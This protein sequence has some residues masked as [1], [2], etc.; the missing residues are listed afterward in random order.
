VRYLEFEGTRDV[1]SWLATPVAIDFQA[2]LGWQPIRERMAELAAYTRERIRLPLATP[3]DRRMSGAMTAFRLPDG[4]NVLALRKALW[5]H[6]IEIPVIERPDRLL[7]RVSHHFYTTEA[8]IDR[9]ADVLP[10][11]LK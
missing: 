5:D 3:A 6:R 11:L 10:G 2:E 4:V 9:L 8:E 1:C 7:I